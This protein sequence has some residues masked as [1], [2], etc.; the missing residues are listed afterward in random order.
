MGN[1]L[2]EL[3]TKYRYSREELARVSGVSPSTIQ[4]IENGFL[5]FENCKLTTLIALA[6][7]FSI[8]VASLLPSDLREKVI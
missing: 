7:A 2:L 8:K 3:R 6:S 5:K 1:K 4:K